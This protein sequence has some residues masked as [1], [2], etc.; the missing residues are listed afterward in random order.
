MSLLESACDVLRTF[1]T[2]VR[3]PITVS[4]T[5]TRQSFSS[6]ILAVSLEPKLFFF[7]VDH[8]SRSRG[9]SQRADRPTLVKPTHGTFVP[10]AKRVET[11]GVSSVAAAP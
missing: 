8:V 6:V 4:D 1:S 7:F 5:V 10:G 9:P 11:H 2:P 3:L